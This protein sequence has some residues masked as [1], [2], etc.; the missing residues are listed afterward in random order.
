MSET[1]IVL[2]AAI[3]RQ[4]RLFVTRRSQPPSMAGF[5]ELPG[6]ELAVDEIGTLQDLFTQEFGVAVSPADRILS[7][8]PLLSWRDPENNAVDAALRIWRC[9]F[10]AEVY[11]ADGEPRPN[12]T[13]YDDIAWL[14]LDEL[15]SVGPWRDE[16]RIAASEVA[17]WFHGDPVWQSAD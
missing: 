14:P 13:R 2:G 1:T 11:F 7:D 6:D 5:W 17:D 3:V 15:D 9:Q 16:A 12:M 10:P 8:R 4:H